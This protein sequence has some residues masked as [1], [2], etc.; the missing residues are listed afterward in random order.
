[1]EEGPRSSCEAKRVRGHSFANPVSTCQLNPHARQG[2]KKLVEPEAH[3]LIHIL[4]CVLK[5]AIS[6]CF[7]DL[8]RIQ[9]VCGYNSIFTILVVAPK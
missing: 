1:M 6:F 9:Q 4:L 3:D 2:K 8:L 7:E 5:Y